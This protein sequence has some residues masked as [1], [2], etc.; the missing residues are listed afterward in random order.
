MTRKQHGV[1]GGNKRI[2]EV[3]RQGTIFEASSGNSSSVASYQDKI[4]PVVDAAW[5]I[6]M[7]A[8]RELRELR[9]ARLFLS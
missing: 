2:R 7:A 5:Y 3:L 9:Q 8:P 4:R 6:V 1:L